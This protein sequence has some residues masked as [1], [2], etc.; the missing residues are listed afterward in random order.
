MQA[1]AFHEHGGSE[2]LI[3]GE[4]PTPEPGDHE[5]LIQVRACALNHLDIWIRNGIPAYPIS[6]PH[7]PG[8]DIAG[9]VIQT[10]RQVRGVQPRDRVVVYPVLH[11]RRCSHCLA[12]RENLCAS[13]RMIGV[14]T[15]GGY[16]QFTR[17]PQENVIPLPDS[18][19]FTTGAAFCLT[20]LTAWHMLVSLAQIQPGMN[21]LV[22]GAS[23]GVGSAAVQIAKLSGARVIA[24]VGGSEK[25]S[26]AQAIGADEVINHREEDLVHR[27]RDLTGGQGVDVVF[28][29][30][31]RDT[32][33]RSIACLSRNGLLVTCGATSGPDVELDLRVL[34]TREIRIMGSYVGTRHELQT[35]LPLLEQG[36]LK[37]EIHSE[38]PL[39]EAR[40]AQQVMENRQHFG[41]IVLIP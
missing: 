14:A 16:A 36:R 15:H 19:D 2:K 9:T 5:V 11:C 6:L 25:I 33:A 30:I 12:G 23:S 13:I 41:K 24:T 18:V 35:L 28:E 38:V 34:F 27:A 20:Y 1:V 31:G 26:K 39:R 4:Y 32:W 10:G 37:P 3:H 40:A 7:I 21:L 22:L 8:T 29:H 17:V